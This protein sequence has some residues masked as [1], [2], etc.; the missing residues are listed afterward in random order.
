MNLYTITTPG[1]GAVIRLTVHDV[2]PCSLRM[3]FVAL[4]QPRL[5]DALDRAYQLE[6]IHKDSLGGCTITFSCTAAQRESLPDEL[7]EIVADNYEE[8]YI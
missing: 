6:R 7:Q 4:E 2:R 1:G 8:H 3:P 5:V